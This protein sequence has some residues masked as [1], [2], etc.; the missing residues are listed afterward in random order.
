[1]LLWARSR[2]FGWFGSRGRVRDVVLERDQRLKSHSR[3]RFRLL[4]V[5]S[6]SILTVMSQ[7]VGAG[8]RVWARAGILVQKALRS[9]SGVVWIAW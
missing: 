1:M 8:E 3:G 2:L 9:G 7:P 6:A 4:N 5:A